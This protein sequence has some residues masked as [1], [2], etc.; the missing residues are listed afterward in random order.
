MLGRDIRS[1]S[2][3][4]D[5]LVAIVMLL[6]WGIGACELGEGGITA[7]GGTALAGRGGN[8]GNPGIGGTGESCSPGPPQRCPLSLC[9]NGVLDMCMA[10]AGFGFCPLAPQMEPCDGTNL[11]GASCQSVGYGSGTLACSNCYIDPSECSPCL[12]LDASLV[13]CGVTPTPQAF[14]AGI[15]ATASEVAT[16]WLEFD[17]IGRPALGFARLTPSLDPVA[18]PGLLDVGPQAP[19]AA[20][21]VSVRV[22]PL[23]SGWVVAGYYEPAVFVHAVDAAGQSLGHTMVEQVPW[24]RPVL[25]SRPGGAP[26]LLWAKPDGIRRS[27][28]SSDGRS[29]S[30][31]ATIANTTE[32]TTLSAT[33]AGDAFYVCLSDEV[34]SS[35]SQ[36]RLLRIESDG[37]IGSAVDVLSGVQMLGPTLIG[38]ADDLR[39]LYST[40]NRVMVWRRVSLAGATLG[41]PVPVE[42]GDSFTGVPAALAFDNDTVAVVGGTIAKGVLG[43]VRISSDGS[44]VTSPRTIASAPNWAFGI[45]DAARSGSDLIVL[46]EPLWLARV[47]M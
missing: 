46:W 39:V 3:R 16:A 40:P 33:Y 7:T 29:F 43:F 36:L 8:T 31:P 1:V 2:S 11:A 6:S 41:P 34:G 21:N 20:G 25:V 30:P 27:V 23:A 19:I 44:I 42:L 12:P 17:A 37:T 26:L 15:A 5:I 47:T 28:I 18:A 32:R 4:S 10:P 22:A 38:G 45:V 14:A 13:R 35:P 9:G 24:T